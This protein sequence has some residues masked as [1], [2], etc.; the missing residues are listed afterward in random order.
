M[1][2]HM[3]EYRVINNLLKLNIINKKETSK[4]IKLILSDNIKDIREVN[5]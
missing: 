1:L 2:S 3:A 5:F 4:N